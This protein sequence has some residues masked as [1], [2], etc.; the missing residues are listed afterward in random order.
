MREIEVHEYKTLHN[1]VTINKAYLAEFLPWANFET[2][3]QD[4]IETLEEWKRSNGESSMMTLGIYYE[5]H[6]V[7]LCGFNTINRMNKSADIGYWLAESHTGKG[8][9]TDCVKSLIKYGYHVLGLNRIAIIVDVENTASIK[10][11]ERL[12][13]VREVKMKEYFYRNKGFYDGFMYRMT[14][15]EWDAL[16]K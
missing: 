10:I 13:F 4:Y 15:L 2:E 8:I 16:K 1:L 9:M 7:G 14:R 11:P 3:P 12:G 6:L 5:D